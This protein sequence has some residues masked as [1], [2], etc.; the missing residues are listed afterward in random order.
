MTA[1]A[2]MEKS[3]IRNYSYMGGSAQADSGFLTKGFTVPFF[4]RVS[5]DV[6]G[7]EKRQYSQSLVSPARRESQPLHKPSK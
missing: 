4:S 1:R 7:V 3:G 6:L 5:G 2:A